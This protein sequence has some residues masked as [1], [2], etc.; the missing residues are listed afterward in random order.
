MAM[1][2]YG[3]GRMACVRTGG[4]DGA[5]EGEGGPGG[6]ALDLLLLVHLVIESRGVRIWIRVVVRCVLLLHPSSLFP[7]T[8]A[9]SR[10]KQ[11]YI[12][13]YTSSTKARRLAPA[14]V[15]RSSARKMSSFIC[16]HEG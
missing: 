7:D 10:R 1:A 5:L 14:P 15:A 9:Q 4:G 12:T 2:R 8:T 11:R 16:R 13:W 6:E 3:Y